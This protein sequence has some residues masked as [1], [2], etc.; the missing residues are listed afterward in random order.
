MDDCPN[1]RKDFPSSSYYC[2]PE[3]Q[4]EQRSR[5]CDHR[6]A[7]IKE[8]MQEMEK[9]ESELKNEQGGGERKKRNKK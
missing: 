1:C 5:E 9:R 2:T 7:E 8:T 3:C 4:L 6:E